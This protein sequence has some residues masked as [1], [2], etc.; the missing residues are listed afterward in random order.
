MIQSDTIL[1]V[2]LY[3][4]FENFKLGLHAKRFAHSFPREFEFLVTNGLKK[5]L[6]V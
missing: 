2:K 6:Y 3:E 1:H 5:C 4:D